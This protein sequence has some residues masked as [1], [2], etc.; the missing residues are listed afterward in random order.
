VAG[1]RAGLNRLPIRPPSS[2]RFSRL[3]RL[4]NTRGGPIISMNDL[5]VFLRG[6]PGMKVAIIGT[7]ISGLVAAWQLHR[8]CD[9]TVFEANDYIG[10]HTQTVNVELDGER[11]AIDTGFIV[12]NHR[13]YPNFTW[14]L[15]CLGV[16]SRPT[17]MSFSV[18]DERTG[19]EYNG[20]SLSTLFAQRSN[21]VRPAFYRMLAD[22][23][24]F[25][26][27]AERLIE[28][29]RE[30]ATVA[31]FLAEHRYSR[32]F[33]EQYLL[34]MGAA[35][36]SCPMGVFAEFPIRFI[37][38]FYRNHGLLSLRDRPVWRVIEGGSRNYV[39]A[40]TAGFRDRIRLRTPVVKV[41]R[42]P[43]GMEV[44]PVHGERERFE[45]VV[46]ACHSDQALRILGD[47]A[48]AAERELLS[49][50]PYERNVAVLHTDPK[51]LPRLR[52]AWASWNY[53]ITRDGLGSPAA[54]VTYNMNILQGLKSKHTFC[55]TLNDEHRMHPEHVIQ[56]YVYHHP[57]FTTRR[58]AVQARHGELLNAHRA[59][60][61]GAYW[62]NGF[63]EDGVNS[64][65]AVVAALQ[66]RPGGGVSMTP[67]L[68]ALPQF[69]GASP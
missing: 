11:H 45:H 22:I 8:A 64:A 30:D 69:A 56:K 60:F 50:F 9:L 38:E 20:S 40:L 49:A 6:A 48:T 17:S 59:S 16:A 1:S 12:F 7:G 36:W 4:P 66:G 28:S 23:L 21:L 68:A 63:H 13:T 41:R 2:R 62:G 33:A 24:R 14:L 46:F 29:A 27:D 25:N 39:Q 51:L 26:R 42:L 65:L 5:N 53:R 61:C 47:D 32:E 55:V 34:P 43:G 35:I 18:H 3:L 58:A 37:V 31:E 67:P 57:V 19:L 54:T 15:N 44:T 52:R 10:G